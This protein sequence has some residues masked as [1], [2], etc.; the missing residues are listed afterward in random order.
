MEVL[1]RDWKLFRKK[2]G[3]WQ[4]AYME[5]LTKQYI[6]LLMSDQKASDKFWELDKRIRK[7]RNHPGVIIEM[8]RS[9]MFTNLIQLL[10]DKVITKEDLADFSDELKEDINQFMEIAYR[11][12]YR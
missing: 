3:P 4:E 2:I 11:R 10:N 12:K 6:E 7:D 1:E 5:R 9:V 8:R